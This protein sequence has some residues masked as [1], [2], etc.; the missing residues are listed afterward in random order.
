MSGSEYVE[1]KSSSVPN[2]TTSSLQ[3]HRLKLSVQAQSGSQEQETPSISEQLDK[4]SQFGYNGLDVPVNVPATPPPPVQRQINSGGSENNSHPQAVPEASATSETVE[5]T[6]SREELVLEETPPNQ[7]S[8]DTEGEGEGVAQ[9]VQPEAESGEEQP[10]KPFL[11][12]QL[13]KASKFGYNALDVGVN[14]PDTPSPRVQRKLTLDGLDNEYQPEVIERANPVLNG[15]NQFKVQRLCDECEAELADKEDK[16][17][18]QAKLEVGQPGDKYEQEADTVAAQVVEKINA[19]Q[20]QQPV[21]RQSKLAKVSSVDTRHI[22]A[23]TPNAH[24]DATVQGLAKSFSAEEIGAIYQSNWERDFS[25]GPAKIAD[26]VIAW[27]QVKLSAAKNG[28][29]PDPQ[30]AETFRSQVWTVI[31]M[32]L[33][34]ATDESLSGYHYWEHMDNP[35]EGPAYSWNNPRKDAD[36]RWQGK[37]NELPGYINDSK[38]YIKDEIVASVDE[39]RSF[40]DKGKVGIGIDNW[41]GVKK[42]EGYNP[43]AIENAA[44]IGDKNSPALERDAIAEETQ[45]QAKSSGAK[46]KEQA[47][48]EK[49]LW[50]AI[51]HHLGRAMHALEDFFAHSNWLEAAQSHKRLRTDLGSEIDT[52]IFLPDIKTGTFEMPDKAHALGHKLSAISEQLLQDFDLLLKVYNK[53]KAS[54]K[55]NQKERGNWLT[56]P[57]MNDFAFGSLETDSWTPAGEMLDVGV[58]ADNMEEM[59]YSG[60]YE[61]ADFLLN[62]EWLTALGNKGKILIEEG[63]KEAPSSGHGKLAKDQSEQGKDFQQAHALATKANQ[64]VFAPL[65]EIMDMGDVDAAKEAL[66]KQLEMVDQMIAIPSDSHPLIGMVKL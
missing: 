53:T 32:N 55:L 35:G 33:A 1:K 13:E 26:M 10:Q 60:N 42:P 2:Q 52:A 48:W 4:A 65:R 5:E 51:G 8:P 36:K 25:Q 23:F 41:N 63:D 64:I 59:I 21:Q 57:N 11:Q 3:P 20:P 54:T 38:A 44:W 15:L 58:A 37:D 30:V 24:R 43:V 56:G 66:L 27:K 14:A 39:Y 61:V 19:P 9:T 7:E 17:P 47:D 6:V 29:N 28:G 45:Q 31:D 50:Q 40:M 62:K 16:Q 49:V 12:A 22:Q 18:V 34:S 46:S